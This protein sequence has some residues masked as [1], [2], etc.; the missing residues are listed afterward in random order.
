MYKVID[1]LTY[2]IEYFDDL[3]SA[4]TW[5]EYLIIQKNDKKRNN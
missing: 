2:S 4:K 1:L 5:V 3:V